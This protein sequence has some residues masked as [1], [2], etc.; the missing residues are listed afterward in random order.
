MEPHVLLAQLRALLADVPSFENFSA[1]SGPQLAWLGRAHALVARWN[2]LEA[3][4]VSTATDFLGLAAT[5]DTNVAKILGVL[6]R[7]VADLELRVASAKGHAFGPGALYDFFTALRDV[8]GTAERQVLVVDPYIDASVF[9]AYLSAVRKG[10]VVRMLVRSAGTD[11]I[12]AADRFRAQ[13]GAALE[14][15]TSHAFHDRAVFIDGPVCWVIGQSIKDA[16]KSMPTYLAPLSADIAEAKLA[17]Y[18]RVWHEARS[19]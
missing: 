2:R 7:A 3:I 4:T 1:S 12:P 6:N 16:A 11:L 19:V 8:L 14:I 17:E 9:D 18:E 15:R 5:R 10:V 13:F